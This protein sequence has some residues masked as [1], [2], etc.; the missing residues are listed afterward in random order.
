MRSS[1]VLRVRIIAAFFVLVAI[2]LILRLYFVQIV[3]GEEYRRDATGQYVESAPDTEE[4]GSIYFTAKDG[5]LVAGAVMQ[6]GWR[7]AIKPAEIADALAV[8]DALNVHIPQ[9]SSP[10]RRSASSVTRAPRKLVSMVWSVNGRR[11]L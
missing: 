1:L 4:R 8:L 5:T 6:T 3:H 7:I 2:L 11:H 10:R 9:D